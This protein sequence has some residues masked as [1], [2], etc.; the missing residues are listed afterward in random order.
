MNSPSDSRQLDVFQWKAGTTLRTTGDEKHPFVAA[1]ACRIL[2]LGVR[3]DG[4]VGIT[5]FMNRLHVHEKGFIRIETLGGTQELVTVSESGLYKLIMRSDKKEALEFQDWV[6]GVVLP[7][8]RKTGAYAADVAIQPTDSLLVA[9]SKMFGQIAREVEALR[10]RMNETDARVMDLKSQ[11]DDAR[12]M[13]TAAAKWNL[14]MLPIGLMMEET[15]GL[16]PAKSPPRR[17][18]PPCLVT[19]AELSRR[20][21]IPIGS[22]YQF[23][24]SG[25]IPGRIKTGRSVY[26]NWDIVKRWIDDRGEGD[27]RAAS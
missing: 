11:V 14:T 27:G 10:Q 18:G 8:I 23:G 3:P 26:F 4:K 6:C 20:T 13:A 2:G 19:A 16:L 25:K 15:M 12:C 5:M 22:V 17:D 21:S 9:Q 7:S 1:D 24:I